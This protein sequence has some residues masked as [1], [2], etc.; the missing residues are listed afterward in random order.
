[1]A[2]KISAKVSIMIMMMKLMINNDDGDD[3]NRRVR[4]L[5]SLPSTFLHFSL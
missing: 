5:H 4:A 3:N 2:D 1:M